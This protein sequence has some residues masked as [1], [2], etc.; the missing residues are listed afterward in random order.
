MADR[1]GLGCVLALGSSGA[2][3]LTARH[4][5][6]VEGDVARRHAGLAFQPL[7][8]RLASEPGHLFRVLGDGGEVDLGEAASRESS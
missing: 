6:G 5:A 3:R 1:P 2:H 4:Q 7:D 8:D